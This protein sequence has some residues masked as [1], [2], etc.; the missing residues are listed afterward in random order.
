MVLLLKNSIPSGSYGKGRNPM[1]FQTDE[2][3]KGNLL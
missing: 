3:A 2:T 1:R